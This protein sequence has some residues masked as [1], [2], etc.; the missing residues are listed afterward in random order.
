MTDPTP[1]P[2]PW[3]ELPATAPWLIAAVA[4]IDHLN[5]DGWTVRIEGHEIGT[6]SRTRDL[7]ILHAALRPT[8]EPSEARH[9]SGFRASVV[10]P[11]QSAP[12]HPSAIGGLRCYPCDDGGCGRR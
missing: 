12:S 6:G 8:G 9:P 10:H 11:D 4:L 7:T 5:G 1:S 3:A 2:L